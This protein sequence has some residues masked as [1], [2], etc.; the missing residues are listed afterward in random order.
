MKKVAIRL[1]R[2]ARFSRFPSVDPGI[3][4]R[5]GFGNGEY[6]YAAGSVSCFPTSTTF[7]NVIETDILNKASIQQ[8]G[9]YQK[10]TMSK[11]YVIV[12]RDFET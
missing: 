11:N 6:S 7:N 4:S 1:T 9:P 8:P 3:A 12:S 10:L 5:Y 2:L